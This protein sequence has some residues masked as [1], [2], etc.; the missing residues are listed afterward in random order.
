MIEI[1][2]KYFGYSK[3][4]PL[5]EQIINDIL[6]GE[7]VLVLMPTGGGKSL[8]FQLPA[9]MMDGLTVVVSPLIALMKD[10]VDSLLAN[11]VAAACINS[12]LSVK[13]ISAILARLK[14]EEIKML[15]VAPE[16]L[17]MP[18]FLDFVKDLK[19]SLFAIDEAH[20]ISEWGHDFRPEYRQLSIL[21]QAFP[22]IPI[23]ALTATATQKVQGDIVEQLNI[24]NAKKYKASFNRTNLKLKIKP[25]IN[26]FE[27]LVDFLNDRK[28][29][30]GIIYCQSRKQVD[31]LTAKLQHAGHK[32]LSYHAGM[33]AAQRSLN[34]ELF[35]KDDA[36]IIVATI[37]FGM[38]ID[39]PNVRFV[40][41]W[42]LPKNIE[43]YYQEI[44][45]SGRDGL[46]SECIL[47]FNYGDKVKQEHF[48]RLKEDAK[49]REIAYKK[50]AEM[51]DF[52]QNSQCRRKTLLLY[53]GEEFGS[54]NCGACDICLEPKEMFDATIAAQK[55]LSSVRR[56][57]GGFGINYIIDILLG[58]KNKKIIERGH[59]KL[60]TYG[61]G[62]EY[63]KSQWQLIVRELINL[64]Y[65]NLDDDRY[66][67]LR[68]NN[69]SRHI[70][71]GSHEI[72][73]IKPKVGWEKTAPQ[74]P[75]KVANLKVD[76][77]LFEILRDVRKNLAD[78]AGL[79]PY[80]IFPDTTLREMAAYYPA[81]SEAISL[82]NGVGEVKLKKYGDAF[83]EAVVLYCKKKGINPAENGQSP[84]KNKLLVKADSVQNK[85]TPA[86]IQETLNYFCQG[87][88]LTEIAQKRFFA[89][90]T[91]TTHLEKLILGGEN[92]NIDN[93]VSKKD[94]E[95]ITKAIKKVGPEM[96]TPIKNY[97]GGKFSYEQIRLVRAMQIKAKEL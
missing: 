83:L 94:Q 42:D 8:C 38:G 10:Q 61:I 21:K 65:L 9:I 3:F 57:G 37:A 85:E 36:E 24:L 4:L 33:N 95:S 15:Y 34:Q 76:A 69:K 52:C 18:D 64:D 87:L 27:Q 97:L 20:C 93:I 91:I 67:V 60:T 58:S 41:H 1:L 48:I 68:L 22:N 11:G 78:A 81:N 14:N 49:E 19:I 35:V 30:S 55:A 92:I 88:T 77:E 82:I 12:F 39:K 26:A 96:L 62:K 29:D 40:I 79:P 13:E 86:T 51:V 72:I 63:Q 53:F 17:M 25:K 32:A 59:D 54:E 31:S 45:R 5:Q 66:P 80:I 70:L 47:F 84:K 56:V 90:S 6:G 44:G 16:R 7:D 2:D 74:K 50:L 73:M 75:E 46:D 28:K 89:V 43:G 71:D 23:A